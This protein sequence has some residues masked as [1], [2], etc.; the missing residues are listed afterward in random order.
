M[1]L[2]EGPALSPGAPEAGGKGGIGPAGSRSVAAHSVRLR[3]EADESD[4]RLVGCWG[5]RDPRESL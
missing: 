2:S 4:M 1:V 5:G 3:N